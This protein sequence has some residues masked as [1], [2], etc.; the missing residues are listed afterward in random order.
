MFYLDTSLWS[1][2]WYHNHCKPSLNFLYLLIYQISDIAVTI[3]SFNYFP[4]FQNFTVITITTDNSITAVLI[5]KIERHIP[6]QC[7]FKC[8]YRCCIV[9]QLTYNSL[10]L[11]L[12]LYIL[13]EC[14]VC[15]AVDAPSPR[16]FGILF[17]L[18]W[19]CSSD[20]FYTYVLFWSGNNFFGLEKHIIVST[21]KCW[22]KMIRV[23]S[24]KI[25]SILLSKLF[26]LYLSKLKK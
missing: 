25:F 13:H 4:N 14:H 20:V 2:K 21:E 17:Y 3:D 10:Y 18:Y 12:W 7:W 16:L 26:C 22:S 19:Y 9:F 23:K 1:I 11:R 6:G 24:L 15:S 8:R 5:N